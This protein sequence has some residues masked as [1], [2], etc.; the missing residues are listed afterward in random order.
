MILDRILVTKE[1]EVAAAQTVRPLARVKADAAAAPAPRG[2]LKA[3]TS[4]PGIQCI[5][6]VKK[7]SP[8]KGIIRPDFDAVGIA[9][10]YESAGAACLSVLTDIQYFQ[11]SLR[12][13]SAIRESVS[14]PLLRKEFI[15]DPYQV[16]E[17]R[18]AGADAILLIVAAFHGVNAKGRTTA[19]LKALVAL[20]E[21]LGMDVL[22]E[23]HTADELAVGL[24]Y[25]G[26]LIGINNRDLRSF[27]TSL[28]VTFSL[29]A[30]VPKGRL[31]VS[32]SGIGTPDEIRRLEAAGVKAALVGESLI[33]QTD[34]A[35]A[36]HTLMGR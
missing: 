30:Q 12:D 2:F 32:E 16:Y 29:A 5:A 18:A 11:G 27:H 17:A 7:A 21:E 26:K 19:D 34:V 9:R 1:E 31:L 8:S 25:G 10:A 28:E 23:V 4:R 33:R 13:L 35:A 3:L 36:L 22:T 24:K 15:I 6:E 20:A 14:L